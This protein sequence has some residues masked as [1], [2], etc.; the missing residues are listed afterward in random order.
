MT[1]LPTEPLLLLPTLAAENPLSHVVDHWH[2]VGGVPI[3]SNHIIMMLVSAGL[4]LIVFGRMGQR[5][6]DNKELVPGGRSNFFETIMLYLRDE[7]AKPTLGHATDQFMPL[8]WTLFFF[9]LFNNLLG[10]LPLDVLTAW[11][12]GGPYYGTSTANIYVTGALAFVSFVV[13]QV[14]GIKA[15]G[16]GGYL[17]H[18]LGGAPWYVAPILIPIEIAGAFIK[19]VALAIRLMAN[20]TGGHL[21]LAILI[22]LAAGAFKTLGAGGGAG[23]SLIVVL[24]AVAIMCLELFVAFL[25]AYIF[26][27]LTA[28]FIGLLVVHEEHD[29]SHHGEDHYG[30]VD[31][32]DVAKLPQGAVEAGAHMAG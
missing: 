30:A 22:G 11:I 28:L 20:M 2:Y 13:I 26:T 16:L 4:M 9:I 17:H 23:V 21:L 18:F 1:A 6:L 19:P 12:P 10:L 15:N 7:V 3:I 8:L 5:Y 27:F 24:G 25:Q 14:S 29:E 32:D 31:L